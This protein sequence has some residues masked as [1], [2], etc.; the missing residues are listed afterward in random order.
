MEKNRGLEM[1]RQLEKQE[2][3]IQALRAEIYPLQE[4]ILLGGDLKSL[5]SIHQDFTGRI[6]RS[7]ENLWCAFCIQINSCHSLILY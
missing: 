5:I 7:F 3:I 1:L 4:S 2:L 6:L